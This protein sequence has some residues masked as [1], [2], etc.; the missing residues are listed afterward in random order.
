[1]LFVNLIDALI[2]GLLITIGI[3][4][5]AGTTLTVTVLIWTGLFFAYRMAVPFILE[6]VIDLF[7]REKTVA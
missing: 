6:G 2:V 7:N 3:L 1:M 4:T 5:T